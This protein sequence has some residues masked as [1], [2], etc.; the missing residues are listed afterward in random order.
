MGIVTYPGGKSCVC[1][2]TIL[3]AVLCVD[4][5]AGMCANATLQVIV[6]PMIFER[7]N[8]P[9]RPTHGSFGHIVAV[10]VPLARPTA[11]RA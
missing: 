3:G 2:A 7:T 5:L 8:E 11:A 4:R 10:A 6:A 1:I 9:A